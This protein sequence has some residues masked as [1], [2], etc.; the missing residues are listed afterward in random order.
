[1][2]SEFCRITS[3][4][5]QIACS[6]LLQSSASRIADKKSRRLSSIT[7][8]VQTKPFRSFGLTCPHRFNKNNSLST[9]FPNGFESNNRLCCFG[10]RI[11]PWIT[12]LALNSY[13]PPSANAGRMFGYANPLVNPSANALKVLTEEIDILPR[14]IDCKWSARSD[15]LRL[16]KCL[17]G[18][19]TATPN[20]CRRSLKCARS[21]M[22]AMQIC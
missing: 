15:T 1:M 17:T 11:A 20:V 6:S 14:H 16:V 8:S 19:K 3:S 9:I 2:S 12:A 10:D 21:A 7:C 4:S 13:S 22:I 18:P 5:A